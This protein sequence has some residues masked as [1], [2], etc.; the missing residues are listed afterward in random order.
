MKFRTQL[1]V[2]KFCQIIFLSQFHRVFMK[3]KLNMNENSLIFYEK[4]VGISLTFLLN[5]FFQNFKLFRMLAV[6]MSAGDKE[7]L[8]MWVVFVNSKFKGNQVQE[9]FN[10]KNSAKKIKRNL[11]DFFI[12]FSK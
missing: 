2:E 9:K 1:G 4:F 10:Y 6:Q 12:K 3:I 11:A 5:L 7:V 8:E